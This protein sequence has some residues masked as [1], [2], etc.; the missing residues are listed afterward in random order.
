MQKTL[1]EHFV[2]G[3]RLR[4]LWPGGV[5][6]ATIGVKNSQLVPLALYELAEQLVL[7]GKAVLRADQPHGLVQ[8]VLHALLAGGDEHGSEPELLGAVLRDVVA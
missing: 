1:A 3:V 6:Q 2:E 4:V 7:P 5:V 8:R